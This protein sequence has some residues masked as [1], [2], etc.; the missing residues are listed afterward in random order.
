MSDVPPD[1]AGDAA[2]GA[3]L[4]AQPCPLCGG[5]WPQEDR[6]LRRPCP[7]CRGGV[8]GKW[9]E[10]QMS[11]KSFLS[12][13]Q[14]PVCGGPW[15]QEDRELRRLCPE[16]RSPRG[17][18]IELR[19]AAE[20][21][22]K[23][24][25]EAGNLE[26]FREWPV[27][28]DLACTLFG[29]STFT[30]ATWERLEGRLLRLFNGDR[31]RLLATRREKIIELLE[32]EAAAIAPGKASP[33]QS[34]PAQAQ[35]E[36]TSAR[37]KR[38]GRRPADAETARREAELAAEWERAKSAGA[39]KGDFAKGRGLTLK[40]F[41]RLLKRVGKRVERSRDRRRPAGD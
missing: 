37:P 25:P 22:Y 3:L 30:K 28:C 26:R 32:A 21:F 14:C 12:E 8:W 7:K 19:V 6:E 24:G 11:G 4:A 35:P 27:I 23:Y 31:E 16:C 40:Q 13:T 15:P 10:L 39:Y 29:D 41:E 1:P 36:P 20:S 33:T 18:W 38:R 9:I 17:K 5:P 34:A 2:D